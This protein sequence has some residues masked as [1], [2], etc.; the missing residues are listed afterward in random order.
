MKKMID[1]HIHTNK[2]DGFLAP[3]EVIDEAIKN[4]VSAIAIADH[5]T[6]DAYDDDLFDYAKKII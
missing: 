5:D 1:L 2:S 3:K 4:E 6:I